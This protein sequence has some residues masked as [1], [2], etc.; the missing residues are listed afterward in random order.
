M[1]INDVNRPK[2]GGR[3]CYLSGKAVI[4]SL[5]MIPIEEGDK[6]EISIMLPVIDAGTVFSATWFRTKVPTD[7]IPQILQ[8]FWD[9]PEACLDNLFG[10]R[11]YLPPD[12]FP[13]RDRRQEGLLANSNS[14]QLPMKRERVRL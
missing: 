14:G 6:T 10:G 8:D 11:G 13:K 9:N 7:D 5:N 12:I 2:M 3:L 4:S 1:R